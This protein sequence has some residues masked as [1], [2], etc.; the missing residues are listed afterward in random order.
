MSRPCVRGALGSVC[1]VAID[2]LLNVVGRPRRRDPGGGLGGGEGYDDDVEVVG[3]REVDVVRVEGLECLWRID[4]TLDVSLDVLD[5]WREG[6]SAVCTRASGRLGSIRS[7][8]GVS[9]QSRRRCAA[10]ICS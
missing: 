1:D 6:T 2:V 10:W 8:S 3:C 9:R 4:G 5:R 7:D